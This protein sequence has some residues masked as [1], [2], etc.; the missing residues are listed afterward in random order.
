MKNKNAKKAVS[1]GTKYAKSEAQATL[2]MIDKL[3]IVRGFSDSFLC[4]DLIP[5]KEFVEGKGDP[6]T[7]RAGETYLV[8][9]NDKARKARYK[10][11]ML[12]FR[13]G[14]K[15]LTRLET[16]VLSGRYRA[17][18]AT[19]PV[20]TGGT[21]DV[22][23]AIGDRVQAC[24]ARREKR[25][26]SMGFDGIESILADVVD[27]NRN[28]DPLAEDSFSPM[29][30]GIVRE[31]IRAYFGDFRW[32]DYPKEEDESTA[33]WT[34]RVLREVRKVAAK[35]D[36]DRADK[37]S[38]KAEFLKAKAETEALIAEGKIAGPAPKAKRKAKA[39][40]VTKRKTAKAK[41]KAA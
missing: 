21:F 1:T 29:D 40:T 31:R 36:S 33:E 27:G 14:L 39:K 5:H 25:W 23:G 7:F 8:S 35:A 4:F 24:R 30:L 18:K 26:N 9:M 6:D 10:S 3:A 41:A 32:K 17:S 28:R 12:K 37:D 19:G 22:K 13:E 20:K 34:L 11:D 15:T 2:R 16:V 38:S